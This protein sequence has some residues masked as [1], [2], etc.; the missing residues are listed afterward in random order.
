[1]NP[2]TIFIL[3]NAKDEVL[4]HFAEIHGIDLM[5]DW[6]DQ[7]IIKRKLPFK[8]L[9]TE[10]TR[11]NPQSLVYQRAPFV[12][13]VIV[14]LFNFCMLIVSLSVSGEKPIEITTSEKIM[15]T[16]KVLSVASF[17]PGF[18]DSGINELLKSGA[19]QT[20]FPLH[21]G[22]W[23][24]TEEGPLNDRQVIKSI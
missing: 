2:E 21:D 17:G 18:F 19:F 11:Q 15:I 20:A 3:I 12:I 8:F 7:V 16:S 4:H 24:W 13:F 6:D 14:L 22:D 23:K 9:G 10:L 5:R 1:M